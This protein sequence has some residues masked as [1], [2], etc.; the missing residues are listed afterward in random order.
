LTLQIIACL[1]PRFV[2][3]IILFIMG[4]FCLW[5]IFCAC[6]ALLYLH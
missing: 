5:C 3:V 1:L 6:S 2:T 4:K